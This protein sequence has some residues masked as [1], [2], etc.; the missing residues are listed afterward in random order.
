MKLEEDNGVYLVGVA[1]RDRNHTRN[2]PQKALKFEL[3]LTIFTT[4]PQNS[5]QE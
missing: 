2:L 5:T 3:Q 1:T 4:N